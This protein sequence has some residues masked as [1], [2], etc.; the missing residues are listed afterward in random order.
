MS[1]ISWLKS[2]FSKHRKEGEEEQSPLTPEGEETPE[3]PAG[4]A[5]EET[6]APV[7]D[8]AST[9]PEVSPEPEVVPEVE[10]VSEPVSEPTEPE[11]EVSVEEQISETSTIQETP[12]AEA[13]EVAEKIAESEPIPEP[14]ETVVEKAVEA[15]EAPEEEVPES[16]VIAETP[17][18]E[19]AVPSAESPVVEETPISEAPVIEEAPVEVS[20]PEPVEAPVS[21]VETPV[22]EAPSESESE[23]V[24][25]EAPAVEEAPVSESQEPVSQNVEPEPVSEP[26]PEILPAETAV[27]EPIPEVKTPVETQTSAV[28]ETPAESTETI[29]E[30]EPQEESVAETIPEEVKESV[31]SE[32]PEPE[33]SESVETPEPSEPVKEVKK[34]LGDAD[35]IDDLALYNLGLGKAREGFS[36]RM[37]RIAKKYKEA[38]S[39]YFDELEECLIEADVGVDLSLR[40]LEKTE[41]MAAQQHLSDPAQINDLLIDNMFLDYAKQGTAYRTDVELDPEHPTVLMVVGVNGTGKTTTI[42]KLALR[43]RERGLKVMVVAADTFRAGAVEQLRIWADRIGVT[44]F[45]RGMGAE[46]ASVCYDAVK[47][48]VDESYDL[49]IVDTAG[50]LHTKDYLMAELGKLV[51]VIGRIIPGAPQEVWLALDANTGQNGVQQSKVFKEVCNLTGIVITKMDGTSKGGIILAIR[52]QLG[53]PV[54]FIGLGEHERDL[55]EFDLDKYL[56]GLLVG[57]EE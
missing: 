34:P 22:E 13:V 3:S 53:I 19:P 39:Q 33:S 14:R 29:E 52:D 8:I 51:R 46:P 40:I 23:P 27:E 4:E 45:D 10:E 16:P 41:T 50:R 37:N 32:N 43:Y 57:G 12:E 21:E 48:A 5:A 49:V 42:A 2:K 20:A 26:E 7:E 56:Y 24:V 15:E 38:N 35:K 55:R 54:R 28:E 11:P 47:K 30:S 25:E 44:C 6:E 17:V 18:E 9:E 1:L 36:K 31:V